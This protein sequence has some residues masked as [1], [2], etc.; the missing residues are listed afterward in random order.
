MK[1]G[2]GDHKKEDKEKKQRVTRGDNTRR[3]MRRIEWKKKKTSER[4]GSLCAHGPT[5][6]SSLPKGNEGRGE[7]IHGRP[8][9]REVLGFFVVCAVSMCICV[10]Y[11]VDRTLPQESS[12]VDKYESLEPVTSYQLPPFFFSSRSFIRPSFLHHPQ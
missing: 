4:E 12:L 10:V 11:V 6:L 1:R 8:E 3:E 7:Q 5:R 2:G 9:E